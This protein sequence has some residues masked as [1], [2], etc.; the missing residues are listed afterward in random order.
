MN[1]F[2]KCRRSVLER[3]D[4]LV[5]AAEVLLVLQERCHVR[6]VERDHLGEPGLHAQLA[7]QRAQHDRDQD[8]QDQQPA[9]VVEDPVGDLA[10]PVLPEFL[11]LDLVV[12]AYGDVGF[13]SP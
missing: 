5:G 1:S 6:V 7:R 3:D 4:D 12:A 2:S 8:E 9:S 13:R 11:P 10:D